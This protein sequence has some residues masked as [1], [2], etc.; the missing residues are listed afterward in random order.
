MIHKFI[1]L[2]IIGVDATILFFQ[3]SEISISSR[4]ASMLYGE[5]SFLQ[6]VIKSSIAIFGQND[7][8]LRFPM[9]TLH[10]LSIILLYKISKN[11]VTQA[12]NRIWMILIF[13]LIPGVISSALLI[14]SAGI[15]ILG[16]LLFVY[17][18]E[19]YSQNLALI[20][21]LPFSIIDAG[22]VYLFAALFIY[23]VYLKNRAMLLISLSAFVISIYLYGV[24]A[25][26]TPVGHFLDSLGI[27]SAIF[28]PII[29]IYLVY[30]LYRKYLTKEINLLWFIA[31]I[32]ILLSLVFSFRQ[33]IEIEH[34]APYL[35][36]AL[37]LAAQTFASSYR[38][39]LKQFRTKYKVIFIISLLFLIFNS[40]VVIFNKELYILLENPKKHFAYKMHIVKELSVKLKE[41]NINCIS[42]NSSMSKRLEFYGISHCSMYELKDITNSAKKYSSVTI[43]Y[44]DKVI[45]QANVTKIN[46]K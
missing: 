15:V 14:D 11:Y 13:V 16:L 9:V 34:F 6:S 36:I 33:R 31:T 12:R 3:S 45:Y 23:S 7:F 44:K 35:I 19:R 22:F 30:I 27:Y 5:P 4:E 26:G 42:T 10:V 2:F 38:V 25:G 17:I 21:L 46:N 28:T 37:P 1:L 29:F 43:S 18:Y 24:D 41:K 40:L 32:P 20:L 8:A 39:R